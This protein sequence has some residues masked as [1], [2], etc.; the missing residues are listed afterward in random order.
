MSNP[1]SKHS[2][3]A[4][5]SLVIEEIFVRTG[6]YK[7]QV[8]DLLVGRRRVFAGEPAILQIDRCVTCIR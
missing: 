8:V 3:S 6:V 2:G 4:E 5:P 1:S 7:T